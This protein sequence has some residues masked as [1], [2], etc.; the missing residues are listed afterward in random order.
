MKKVV[1]QTLAIVLTVVMLLGIAP[2]GNIAGLSFSTKASALASSGQCGENVYWNFNKTTGV[3]TISGTGAMYDSYDSPFYNNSEIK[4]VVVQ[5]GVTRIGDYAFNGCEGVTNVELPHSLLY[6]GRQAFCGCEE[7]TEI[8]IPSSV[9]YIWDDAFDYCSGL[10]AIIVDK[11]NTAYCSD[12]YGVLYNKDKTN[13]IKYPVGNK[14]T[15]YSISAGVESISEEAFESS[16]SLKSIII[17]EGVISIGQC[18]FR[19]CSGIS[20]IK[21]PSSVI[22]IG[23]LA[24]SECTELMNISLP[25]NYIQIG[26]SVFDWTAYY[27]NYDNWE[28]GIL[29]IGKHLIEARE[30]VSGTYSIKEGTITVAD[31]AFENCRNLKQIIIPNSVK[32]I[33]AG[34]FEECNSLTALTIPDSVKEIGYTAFYN[35]TNLSDIY[36]SGNAI[37]FWSIYNS[38]DDFYGW[39]F[40]EYGYSYNTICVDYENYNHITDLHFSN[41]YNSGT[42]G[43]NLTWSFDLEDP[44]KALEIS[45]YGEMYDDKMED[46][47]G[48]WGFPWWIFNKD[49]MNLELEDGITNIPYEAYRYFTKLKKVNIPNSIRKIDSAAFIGCSGLTEINMSDNIEEIAHNSFEDTGYFNNENNWKNG[50]LYLG[51]C[52]VSHNENVPKDYRVI[53]GTKTIASDAFAFCDNLESVILP[54]GLKTICDGAFFICKNMNKI[55][56]P[57]SVEYI[58]RGAFAIDYDAPDDAALINKKVVIY[59]YKDSYAHKYAVDNK[60]NYVL[61][62]E[63]ELYTI[64]YN[65]NGGSN[66]PAEQAKE[67]DVDITLSTKIPA[68]DGYKFLGWSTDKNAASAQYTAGAKITANGNLTLYAVWQANSY[69]VKFYD[70][71]TLLGSKKLRFDEASTLSYG[72]IPAKKGYKFVGW[73]IING[74]PALFSN[75]QSIKGLAKVDGATVSYYAAWEKLGDDV[76]ADSETGIV[77]EVPSG[78]YSDNVILKVEKVLSGSAFDIVQEQVD[79]GKPIVFSIDTYVNDVKTQPDGNVTVKIPVPAGFNAS[80]CKLFY[81]NTEKEILENIPFTVK[82]SYIVFVTNHF[83]NWAIVETKGTVK[84]VSINDVELRYKDSAKLN[85]KI[86]VDSGVKYTVEYKSS[87]PKVATVDSNGNLKGVKDWG[88]K[89]ATITCTVTDEYGNKVS[90]TCNVKVGYAWWQWIIGIVLFGWIWY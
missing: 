83:S 69:T 10:T 40:Y 34:A 84:S 23:A 52:L 54:D 18:A 48:C 75:G 32:Y 51:N 25:N 88:K 30:F 76:L 64:T 9:E 24:F 27:D 57:R 6:I 79:G 71:S 42:C 56:I 28:N 53:D 60:M 77:V 2:L 1:K 47:Y 50:V 89:T 78:T 90:D 72:E 15:L 12:G 26:D 65:G 58:S 62:D 81:V 35:C 63:S 86:E 29:Y 11:N 31:F 59:C 73:S 7:L 14:R 5:N 33:G 85:P 61:L 13:L 49:V 67:K 70:G 20:E 36:Y 38:W 46:V 68:K 4:K 17:P 55:V 66:V 45:G 87:N 39:I 74:G 19:Y 44:D 41:S 22:D 8:T 21:I 43:D 37:E 3:L 80:K 82:D 16:S